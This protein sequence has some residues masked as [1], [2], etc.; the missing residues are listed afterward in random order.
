MNRLDPIDVKTDFHLLDYIL[1]EQILEKDKKEI[2]D[3]LGR[4]EKMI[5][6]Y[7]EDIKS[8][9]RLEGMTEREY[10]LSINESPKKLKNHFA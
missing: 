4:S 8:T 10:F 3:F 5:Q 6:K 7:Y 1:D 2:T 9:D